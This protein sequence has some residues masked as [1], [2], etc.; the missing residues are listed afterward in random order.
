MIF[1]HSH[2]WKLAHTPLSGI[3]TRSRWHRVTMFPFHNL[4]FK[5]LHNFN[6]ANLKRKSKNYREIKYFRIHPSY[7]IMVFYNFGYAI[8]RFQSPTFNVFL[9][10]VG[11]L[12]M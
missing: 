5:M 1:L 3:K 9:S 10:K 12:Y 7:K 2:R 6:L 4:I 8:Q 11:V